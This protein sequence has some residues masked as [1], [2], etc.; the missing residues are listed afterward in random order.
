M[1][2]EELLHF[3]WQHQFFNR[4]DLQ[5]ESGEALFIIRPGNLNTHSGPD[6]FNGQ[7]R[8][9]SIIWVG[10]IEIHLKSSDWYAH[11]HQN[12]TA[13]SKVILHVVWEHD[14]EVFQENGNPIPVLVLKGRVRKKLIENYNRLQKQKSWIPCEKEIKDVDQLAKIQMLDRMMI[15]RLERKA[16]RIE[17]LLSMHK[18]DWEAV[19][20][21]LTARYFGFKVN[22]LPFEL[23]AV[24]TPYSLFRKYLH[25]EI[26]LNALLYGQAGFL[27]KDIKD[28]Y[29]QLLKREYVH[30]KRLHHLVPMEQSLWKFMRMR[31]SNFPT[32]RISQ[33]IN[34]FRQ[35]SR[36][37]DSL[38]S[39]SSL[40]EINQLLNIQANSYWDSHYQ[41][42]KK[43]SKQS[44]KLL[45]NN[46]R[47]SLIIN[48][49][50]PLLFTWLKFHGREK[51]EKAIELLFQLK[52]ENNQVIRKWKNTGLAIQSA[53]DS[54]AALQLKE[55]FCDIK[56]CLNCS[57][58]NAI[59][60]S[61]S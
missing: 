38:R 28:E 44:K 37:F 40:Q 16:K 54:Q 24:N 25:Q 22:A 61:F 46:A 60:K 18:N 33:F 36:I 17:Q 50:V 42:G 51:P 48:M 8:I 9:G 53:H 3:T 12:D 6:F 1:F 26:A 34:L 39:C 31:P 35:N 23:L 7:I 55:E 47:D 30:L 15:D 52:A 41:F 19:F 45:G 59:L 56:K 5:T 27:E 10:N 4:E 13:Y 49:L 20:Y 58:G 32:I 29:H 43:S 11:H 2:Y 21:Q 14:R 57:I